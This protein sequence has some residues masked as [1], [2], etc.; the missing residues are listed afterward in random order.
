M[1][2]IFGVTYTF[3]ANYGSCLQ[4]YALQNTIESMQ[5]SDEPVRYSLIPIGHAPGYAK[6]NAKGI[7]PFIKRMITKH[8]R[9]QFIPFEKKYMHYAPVLPLADFREYNDMADCFVC[10]SDVVWN[11]T[12]NHGLSEY[13]L[14][15]AEKY[16][17]SYAASF[18]QGD[19]SE[20]HFPGI[21][22]LLERLDS[23]S[24]REPKSA[25]IVKKCLGKDVEVTVDPV[26]LLDRNA[27][28]QIAERENMEGD[29]ILVYSVC[30]SK[31][32]RSFVKKL[33]EQTGLKVIFSGGNAGAVLKLGVGRAQTPERWL[34]LM[35]DAKYVVTDS[36]HGTVFSALFH[37]TFFTIVNQGQGA[38][39][40]IRMIDFL[41]GIGLEDR[42]FSSLPDEINCSEIDY[43]ESDARLSEKI[44]R[45]KAFLRKNLEAA[46]MRK[47]AQE[48]V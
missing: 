22:A 7:K 44:T 45:S 21:G 30:T 2:K 39:F 25:E 46:Y 43:R 16:S 27:W 4:A 40:N 13:F 47:N 36:F 29:Y 3:T 41:Q 42:L 6:S 28:N 26:L 15:F 38:G 37:R 33:S 9:K 32:L 10:G 1:L 35:R 24:V 12:F 23:I 19:V 5:I 20:S 11:P 34:Q 8:S 31:L 14:S 17:F 18:G 48:E